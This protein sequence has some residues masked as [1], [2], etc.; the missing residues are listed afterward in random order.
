M[1]NK[2][3]ETH[4]HTTIDAP[5]TTLA[6]AFGPQRERDANLVQ[7]LV[8]LQNAVS[9][10]KRAISSARGSN[11]YT[12]SQLEWILH[13]RCVCVSKVASLCVFAD[14]RMNISADCSSQEHKGGR[15]A[16]CDTL[17]IMRMHT[18]NQAFI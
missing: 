11:K 13:G 14:G 3:A 9:L 4:L 7:Q 10:C 16:L 12:Q 15:A 5:C 18:H 6:Y 2:A 17:I 8:P 1:Y